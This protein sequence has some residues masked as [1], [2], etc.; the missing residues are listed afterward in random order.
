MHK[1]GF[2]ILRF[3][4]TS[5]KFLIIMLLFTSSSRTFVRDTLGD[6]QILF[7]LIAL[8]TLPILIT[9]EARYVFFLARKT[10]V[11]KIHRCAFENASAG[12]SC[13]DNHVVEHATF[14]SM[15]DIH[16]IPDSS[17]EHTIDVKFSDDSFCQ[18]Q[19][20]LDG[21]FQNSES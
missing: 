17:W 4:S 15:R 5:L 3:R 9:H 20:Q 18:E 14:A 11:S 8:I 6:T 7:P 12:D 2:D 21:V 13:E 19:K 16:F 10:T 1:F